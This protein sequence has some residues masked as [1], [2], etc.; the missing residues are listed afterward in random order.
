MTSEN[1]G[2]REMTCSAS[3]KGQNNISNSEGD[4]EKR[5]TFM[6]EEEKVND[7]VDEL[8]AA[9]TPTS[10]MKGIFDE[11]TTYTDDLLQDDT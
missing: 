1:S 4:S 6:E 9:T 8:A 7:V 5:V 3:E 11:T 10:L 2:S